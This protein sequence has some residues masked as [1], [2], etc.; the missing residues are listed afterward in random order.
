M[1]GLCCRYVPDRETAEDL[2]HSAFLQAIGKS[3]TFRGSG[4]FHKW[5]MR[6]TVNTVLQYLRDNERKSIIDKQQDIEDMVDRVADEEEMSGEGEMDAILKANFTQEEIMEAIPTSR[7]P[8]SGAS[9]RT[10]RNRICSGPA[11]NCNK[12]YSRNQ[13]AKNNRL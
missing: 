9:P 4:S 8:S 11:R 12:Y 10:L 7:L 6:I 1:I 2:A 3:D 5:L 13:N